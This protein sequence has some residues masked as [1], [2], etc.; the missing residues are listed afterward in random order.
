M[1]HRYVKDRLLS[2][3]RL[4]SYKAV[5]SPSTD[6]E[7]LGAYLWGCNAV[8][9]IYPLASHVEVALRNSV[10]TAL[11]TALGTFWWSTSKL[12]YKSYAAGSP[13]P[14]EVKLV[15][16]KFSDATKAYKKSEAEKLGCEP[17]L[18]VPTH[19]GVI[20]KTVFSTWEA[21]FDDEFSSRGLIWPAHLG[22]VLAGPWPSTSAT[23]TRQRTRDLV[24]VVR[25]FRNRLSHHEP[26]WKRY[27]VHSPQ[28]A[29]DVLKEK[30]DRIESLL[31]LIH[32]S[33]FEFVDKAGFFETARYASSQSAL[34]QA[35]C[36]AKQEMFS[37]V[38][39]AHCA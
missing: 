7:L 17:D 3:K 32:P 4:D 14:E 21:I 35:Q 15:R 5:F 19:E 6:A 28:D 38:R 36:L 26:A 13:V 24:Q 10:D 39:T 33:A 11:T 8:G 22:R 9:A 12:H 29:F 16:G 27:G 30:I 1:V 2:S 25:A 34:N 23:T 20:S 31:K 18:I 37:A